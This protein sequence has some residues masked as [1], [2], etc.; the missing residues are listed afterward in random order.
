ME[1]NALVV[2]LVVGIANLFAFC[3]Y[4][5]QA[6]DSFGNMTNLLY[7]EANWQDLSIQLRKY[8]IF[9]IQNTQRPLFYHGFGIAILNLETFLKVWIFILKVFT[10]LTVFEHFVINHFMDI[11]I[12]Q[13]IRTVITYY[14]VFKTLAK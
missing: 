12:Y 5:K 1:L 11:F 8:L 6:T 3:W 9:M 4:G 14:M 10:F 7:E 2:V 13:M